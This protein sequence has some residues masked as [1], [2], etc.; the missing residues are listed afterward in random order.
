MRAQRLETMAGSCTRGTSAAATRLPRW[1]L[2]KNGRQRPPT[3]SSSSSSSL[4]RNSLRPRS[5]NRHTR[6]WLWS[7]WPSK[8]R[9]INASRC[10][11]STSTL[12]PSSRTTRRTKRVGRTQYGT[13]CRW[14]S[15]S[16]KY[17]ETVAAVRK[18]TFGL[19]VRTRKWI[20]RV[21]R[22]L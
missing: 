17:L 8:I 5:R 12:R 2:P 10:P 6:T 18:A 22:F 13:T 16:T 21:L 11:K 1:N 9:R 19:W 7:R 14:T 15:V 3:N 4:W 20:I